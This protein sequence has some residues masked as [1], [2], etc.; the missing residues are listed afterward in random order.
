M[1]PAAAPP[2][3]AEASSNDRAMNA[4][5]NDNTND[6]SASVCEIDLGRRYRVIRADVERME[7]ARDANRDEPDGF[8]EFTAADFAL[9]R[10]TNDS[11]RVLMTKKMRE[12]ALGE[13]KRP[14]ACVIRFVAPPP[15][16][17]IVEASFAANERVDAM[18]AFVKKCAKTEDV[19]GEM[20]L[21]VT[22]PKRV[23]ARGSA[24]TMLDA[25]L[26][27]AA[28]VRVGVKGGSSA[29]DSRDAAENALFREDIIALARGPVKKTVREI[30]P[31]QAS[32]PRDA[33]S[34]SAPPAEAEG[35]KQKL[36]DKLKAG[37]KPK[38]FKF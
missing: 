34:A 17:L 29:F 14:T 36:L 4:M 13:R 26:A 15:S 18:Y 20:E 2:A 3:S 5:S 16:D 10:T 28:R 35:K 22:P 21:F 32:A 31:C 12:N 24:M 1:R 23:F 8:Y 30:A 11:E 25:G 19:W 38:W 27:P 7:G 37:G 33:G 6:S 9:V